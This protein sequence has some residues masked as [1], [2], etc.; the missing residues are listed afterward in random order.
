MKQYFDFNSFEKS[1]RKSLFEGID[2]DNEAEDIEDAQFEK[3]AGDNNELF[4]QEQHG[5]QFRKMVKELIQPLFNDTDYRLI[6]NVF[7]SYIKDDQ[8]HYTY[9]IC[10]IDCS[11]LSNDFMF[12]YCFETNNLIIWNYSGVADT[13][14]LCY[15]L[16]KII[17]EC[18]LPVNIYIGEI[19]QFNQNSD[20]Q[21]IVSNPPNIIST[22]EYITFINDKKEK[23]PHK[24]FDK[25][26]GFVT[27][28]RSI[29]DYKYDVLT[30]DKIRAHGYGRNCKSLC[31]CF[32]DPSDYEKFNK[33]RLA[34]L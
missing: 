32:E 22:V 18:K 27:K 4:R 9:I 24:F 8:K 13:I 25:F 28:Y 3:T 12:D 26:K 16:E 33:L 14:Y 21:K 30:M 15:N 19:E 2:L 11:N 23:F 17:A 6:K 31:D 1:I 5:M 20:L 7:G 34:A 29:T 10:F